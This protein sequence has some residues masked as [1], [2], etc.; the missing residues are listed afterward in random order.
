MKLSAILWHRIG[1]VR[2]SFLFLYYI[3]KVFLSVIFVFCCN[4]RRSDVMCSMIYY[5]WK[6][7]NC[8]SNIFLASQNPCLVFPYEFGPDD[9]GVSLQYD[10]KENIYS[11]AESAAVAVFFDRSLAYRPIFLIRIRHSAGISSTSS[12]L[13]MLLNAD[14]TDNFFVVVVGLGVANFIC[15]GWMFN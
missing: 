15:T 12:S 13:S 14:A 8:F 1:R 5:W 7:R 4:C 11:A 10:E 9:V 2:A 3:N 6:S